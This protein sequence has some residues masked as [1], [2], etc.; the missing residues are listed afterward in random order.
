M[1]DTSRWSPPCGVGGTGARCPEGIG[2]AKAK[3]GENAVKRMC[4]DVDRVEYRPW[5]VP[6]L[7]CGK[8]GVCCCNQ[9]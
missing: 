1:G 4:C 5:N 3:G 8:D 9:C 7:W 6:W 2:G